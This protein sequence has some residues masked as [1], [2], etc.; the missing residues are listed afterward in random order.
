MVLYAPGDFIEVYKLYP[1]PSYYFGT[2]SKRTIW[3]AEYIFVRRP[4][5]FARPAISDLD[6][7]GKDDL[8]DYD[9]S[10]GAQVVFQH[11]AGPREG[12]A[13]TELKG[14]FPDVPEEP[15]N[16]MWG[17]GNLL[18]NS[19]PALVTA[20]LT[21]IP[22]SEQLTVT[23]RIHSVPE[24]D[25]DIYRSQIDFQYSKILEFKTTVASRLATSYE[26]WLYQKL[27]LHDI[28]GDSLP[29]IIMPLCDTILVYDIVIEFGPR[30]PG[31]GGFPESQLRGERSFKATL[32]Q[33]GEVPITKKGGIQH[34]A[35]GDVT[36]DGIRAK[37]TGNMDVVWSNPTIIALLAAPPTVNNIG[38]NQGESGT[39]FGKIATLTSTKTDVVGTMTSTTLEFGTEVEIDIMQSGFELSIAGT[40]EDE[41]EKTYSLGEIIEYEETWEVGYDDHGVVYTLDQFRRWEYEIVSHPDPGWLG[42]N[43]TICYPIAT[44]IHKANLRYFESSFPLY[45]LREIID[46]FG[47]RIVGD[48][49]SYPSELEIKPI[50]DYYTPWKSVGSG[51][52]TDSVTITKIAE[53]G[54]SYGQTHSCGFTARA[55]VKAGTV[56]TDISHSRGF[57][58]GSSKELVYGSGVS[59]SGT[60]GDIENP[61]NWKNYHYYYGMYV[62]HVNARDVNRN[63]PPISFWVIDYFVEEYQ[64]LQAQ[65]ITLQGNGDIVQNAQRG[66]GTAEDPYILAGW[67]LQGST[68]DLLTIRDTDVHFNI[69][70]GFFNGMGSSNK[71][72]Y[73]ENVTNAIILDNEFMGSG[74]GIF[75]TECKDVVLQNNIIS[76]CEEEGANLIFSKLIQIHSNEISGCET[77]ISVHDCFEIDVSSNL[78]RNNGGF[79]VQLLQV[80][81][82]YFYENSIKDNEGIGF[83]IRQ[84]CTLNSLFDNLLSKN[85]K[86]GLAIEHS[87]R[88]SI[89]SNTF[90]RNSASGIL[91]GSYANQNQL[92]DNIL[93]NN[94]E[95]GVAIGNCTDNILSQN[96]ISFNMVHGV[97]ISQDAQE[98]TITNNLISCNSHHGVS[99]SGAHKN[100]IKDNIISDN[101]IH[102]INCDN[103]QGNMILDNILDYNSLS[104]IYLSKSAGNTLSNN[105]LT[106]G[107]NNGIF[108]SESNSNSISYNIIH[109]KTDSGMLFQFSFGNYISYNDISFNGLS[110]INFAYRSSHNHLVRNSLADNGKGIIFF[111]SSSNYL[112]RNTI[113]NNDEYAIQLIDSSYSIISQNQIETAGL[114]GIY[115]FRSSVNLLTRNFIS[116]ISEVGVYFDQSSSN[117]LIENHFTSIGIA[118]IK[119]RLSRGNVLVNNTL[120]LSSN[121][122]HVLESYQILIQDNLLTKNNYGISIENSRYN[123]V[124]MNNITLNSEMGIILNDS[125]SNSVSENIITSNILAIYLER[126]LHNSLNNNTLTENTNGIYLFWSNTNLISVNDIKIGESNG[127]LLNSSENNLIELN[128]ISTNILNGIHLWQ[129]HSNGLTGNFISENGASGI[130]L[131]L[132]DANYLSYNTL[133]QNRHYGIEIDGVNNEITNNMFVENKNYGIY[134][135]ST[136]DSN[137]ITRNDFMNNAP[138]NTAQGF[139]S[140]LI[141]AILYNYWDDWLT[142]DVD[143]DSYVDSPYLLDGMSSSR[144]DYPST[145]SYHNLMTAELLNP[146]PGVY[147]GIITVAWL[148]SSD[149]WNHKIT[150]SIYWSNDGGYRW[151]LIVSGLLNPM[152]NWDTALMDDGHNYRI[153]VI[154]TCSAGFS[155]RFIQN[156]SFAISN[157]LRIPK[158]VTVWE[159]ASED[160]PG[161]TAG[162]LLFTLAIIAFCAKRVKKNKENFTEKQGGAHL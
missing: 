124:S 150:Y 46:R 86:S 118:G 35:F 37:N 96:T 122:I 25:L 160:S 142:P 42:A 18:G 134:L 26:S 149:S 97:L 136:S 27:Y 135:S 117:S 51:I 87:W 38:Q 154:S 13:C 63:L 90:E 115:S 114:D 60:V 85:G 139:D 11:F 141:N 14:V 148:P 119:I 99:I 107:S 78:I 28:D 94:E 111:V 68:A 151:H 105:L 79:G 158:T 130:V 159:E 73:L 55:R 83:D 81:A 127:L 80:N 52:G 109:K 143:N 59:F 147:S 84:F 7:D 12:H 137:E 108:F 48:P 36:G 88:N 140:G 67:A 22:S 50:C 20:V 54:Q 43:M 133:M 156:S 101:K 69:E 161:W 95:N 155:S 121:G 30:E 146:G 62:A 138:Q 103:S 106:K 144:D 153:M 64:G 65:G 98:Q 49:S 4:I 34:F 1:T 93:I 157:T 2:L 104:G 123:T 53:K 29:E 10:Q 19:K 32:K 72:L 116:K 5:T 71:G 75:L 15:R 152:F 31:K 110:G 47:S 113:T 126:S 41:V 82:S 57:F 91:I 44:T 21:P 102:G 23:F 125:D 66:S 45:G 120:E 3:T 6:H 131:E 76:D 33:L 39:A 145:S 89:S 162:L 58:Y 40:I 61:I 100:L 16:M 9:T 56:Y 92:S 112:D 17:S 128:K 129:S 77:G 74:T 70:G 132:S 8:L 24:V